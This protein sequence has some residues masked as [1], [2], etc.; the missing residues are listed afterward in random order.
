[1]SNNWNTNREKYLAL[2][3]GESVS[4]FFA[5]KAPMK[6]ADEAYPFTPNRNF[7]YLTGLD[8]EALVLILVKTALGNEATL[9]IE[10]PNPQMVRWV[11]ATMTSDEVSAISGISKVRYLDELDDIV[12]TLF[13]RRKFAT[14][15]LDLERQHVT[16]ADSPAIVAAKRFTHAY[17]ALTLKKAETLLTQ[18]R[19]VKSEAEIAKIEAAIALTYRGIRA[20][21]RE[22]APGKFENEIEAYFDLTLKQGGASDFAFPTICAAGANATILH[23]HANNAKVEANDLILFDL[24]AQIDYYNA[25]ISRTFPISGTFTERQKVLYEIVL[26][27][28]GAVEAH[29]RPGITMRELNEVA[30]NHLSKGCLAIGL[31]SEPSQIHDYYIHSIGHHLGLDTHDV[32][33]NQPLAAGMVITNEPGLYIEAEGIGI[34]IEDDLLVTE[35]GCR[36]LSAMIPKTVQEVEEFVKN[37]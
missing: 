16:I 20:M 3:E 23:Y 28:M 31:I 33:F 9:L 2:V 32:S 24:G 6:S 21:V 25:D 10:R 7:Y 12:S 17:P 4:L 19:M 37:A 13:E 1:M 36:N 8:V 34:R 11:G 5:G 30:I 22:F 35:T 26:G 29:V 14:C 27:A 18:L 15:Y